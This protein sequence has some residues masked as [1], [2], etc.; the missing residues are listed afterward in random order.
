MK[1]HEKGDINEQLSPEAA[2]RLYQEGGFLVVTQ[3]PP[4]TEF[5]IDLYSWNTG[6]K[7]LGVKMIPPGLH[8][9]YYSTLG[10]GSA[11][12]QLAPRTGF[13]HM[14]HRGDVLV[15]RYDKS[16]EE[17]VDVGDDEVAR[18]REG[19]KDMDSRL[20][21]YPLKQWKKWVSLSNRITEESLLRLQPK[22]GTV[23]AVT[24]VASG[25]GDDGGHVETDP[26]A[27][28]NYTNIS[29]DRHPAGCSAKEITEHAMDASYRLEMFVSDHV[30]AEEVLVELQFSF[31]CF[32]V[33]QNYDSFEQ[34]K[35]LVAL[36]CTCVKAMS[37]FP[38]LFISFMADLHFQMQEVPEDFFVDIISENN[39]LVSSLSD[40]FANV[41][42]HE[43]MA[44]QL[45]Q[46]AISFENHLTKKFGWDFSQED[47]EYAPTV[48][49]L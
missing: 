8:F 32:L 28:I 11:G 9:V 7:F 30:A 5:G 14:F 6:E 10:Q 49:E 43:D 29:R 38:D 12:P 41:R 48:V 33:A 15:K 23:C 37:K 3:L 46:K 16:S 44:P 27:R 26:E 4:G 45:R 18:V 1:E 39:F 31:L 24:Q 35:H 42:E 34:W 13:F 36:L 40:L 25:G 17:L 2:Q 19:L 21:P 20:G 47:E 22:T